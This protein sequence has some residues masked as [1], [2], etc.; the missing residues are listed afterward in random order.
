MATDF[1]KRLY[2]TPVGTLVGKYA[3]SC[4]CRSP[5]NTHWEVAVNDEV[6][7][8]KTKCWMDRQLDEL[9]EWQQLTTNHL[10]FPYFLRAAETEQSG[11]KFKPV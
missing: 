7:E 10:D 9:L 2:T 11:S 8:H 4:G 5:K 6:T 1:Y 3:R